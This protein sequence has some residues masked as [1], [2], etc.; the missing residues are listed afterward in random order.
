MT[1]HT[2]ALKV[3]ATLL[4]HGTAAAKLEMRNPQHFQKTLG[5]IETV[6]H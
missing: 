4:L 5:S 3:I 6:E 1:S 2:E